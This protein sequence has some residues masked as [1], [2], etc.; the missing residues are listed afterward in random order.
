MIRFTADLAHIPMD[1][2]MKSR[3]MISFYHENFR[4]IAV[5]AP[6]LLAAEIILYVMPGRLFDYHA[7]ILPFL[8][9]NVILIPAVLLVKR[10]LNRLNPLVIRIVQMTY[11]LSVLLLG[12]FLSLESMGIVD[13][14]HMML[15]AMIAVATFL[16]F[17]LLCRTILFSAA[18]MVFVFF[19]PQYQPDPDIRFVVTANVFVFGLLCWLL[20]LIQF[21]GKVRSFV[22][23]QELLDKSS[24]LKLMAQRDSMTQLF[25]HEAS[26]DKLHEEIERARRIGYPL[27]LVITDIDDFKQINDQYGHQVGD[28]VIKQIARTIT[29]QMRATDIVGRYGGE[30]FIMILPDTDESAAIHL[31][32]RVQA[33]INEAQKSFGFSVTLSGGISEYQGESIDMFI[34]L[35]DEKL[36]D[37]KTNGKN[38]FISQMPEKF[39]KLIKS[40]QKT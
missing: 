14:V 18:F 1:R 19:L 12:V 22:R 15:M 38:K 11:A 2:Q 7:V 13:F 21:K 17:T 16:T 31:I 36:Y 24:E 37:A 10:N 30:E 20:S 29:S 25:N 28:R 5:L 26:F 35:T 8:L 4:R 3:M 33:A 32:E 39:S 27:T 9:A 40:P 23:H 34:R 6:V